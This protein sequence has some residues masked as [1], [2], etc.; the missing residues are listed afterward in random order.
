MHIVCFL[1]FGF[2]MIPALL[3]CLYNNLAFTNLKAY[4][5]TSYWLL[6]Q[7]RVVTTGIVY[8]VR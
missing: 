6:L 7:F 8:Q 5:P 2:Y 3:Y 4:G 1:V